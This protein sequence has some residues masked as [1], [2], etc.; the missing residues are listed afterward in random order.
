MSGTQTVKNGTHVPVMM[1]E[2]MEALSLKAGD[3]I[4]DGT[5]GGGGHAGEIAKKISP[6]GTLL[7]IDN[8]PAVI[9]R[10]KIDA[11]DVKVILVN[12]NY[13]DAAAV[14]A[15]KGLPK[16]DGLLLDLG[17][18]SIQLGE[19]RGF[20]FMKD[21]PLLMTYSDDDEPLYRALRRLS[22][23]DLKN[24]ISVSGERFARKLA[25]AIW[26]AERKKPI[27]TT[28]EL[29]EVIR[30]A[31]PKGYE[32]GRIHPATRT[33]LAFRIYINKELEGLEKVIDSLPQI[34]KPGGRVA[35]ITFQ[36]LED[37][38]VKNR[39]REMAKEGLISI[40]TKKPIP[41]SLSETRDNPRARSA[42]MR[43]AIIN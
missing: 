33:F 17:F 30:S 8:D 26:H 38:V 10:V 16:A 5:L 13:S 37:R 41:V 27:G 19:G 15:D 3:F 23:E 24:V 4:I 32:R 20:S 6:G 11:P 9:E 18:S 7:G 2:V 43:S 31:V 40:I 14:L 1:N 22:K 42:K 28:G 35:I 25:E 21:E 36:S 39:F 34:I 29:V 12:A